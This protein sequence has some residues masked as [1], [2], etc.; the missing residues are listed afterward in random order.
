[1]SGKQSFFYT[2][3][4]AIGEADCFDAAEY[5][6]LMRAAM[7]GD[8]D[9][10]NIRPSQVTLARELATSRG[11]VRRTFAKAEERG[12]LVRDGMLN[13]VHVRHAAVSTECMPGYHGR[14]SVDC[15]WCARGEKHPAKPWP[16][17]PGKPA[18]GVAHG[19][20]GGGTQRAREWHTADQGVAHGDSQPTDRPTELPTDLPS[21]ISSSTDNPSP[22]KRRAKR[23]EERKAQL[24]AEG[25]PVRKGW[26]QPA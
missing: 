7:Y 2:W 10:R 4:H 22:M 20:P 24:E 12:V 1:M 25:K 16:K 5:G 3:A 17:K 9:G 8:A 21:D 6:I 15:V 11:K 18:E 23:Q 13:G 26:K 19:E 14:Q